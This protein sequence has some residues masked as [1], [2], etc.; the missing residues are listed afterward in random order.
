MGAGGGVVG[1][2]GGL[3]GGGG[4]PHGGGG[5]G[6]EGWLLCAGGVKRYSGY[7]VYGFGAVP[8]VGWVWGVWFRGCTGCRVG[9]GCRVSGPYRM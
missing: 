5:S 1:P 9:M 8:D 7:G 4:G 6:H 3:G 2:T